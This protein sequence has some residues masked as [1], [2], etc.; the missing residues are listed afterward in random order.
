[1]IIIKALPLFLLYGSTISQDP[2]SDECI[3]AG[4]ARSN[5]Q[6]CQQATMQVAQGTVDGS[7]ALSDLETYCSETCRDL[8]TRIEEECGVS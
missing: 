7:F 8:N 1:M 6:A 3:A 4:T 2:P 5:N